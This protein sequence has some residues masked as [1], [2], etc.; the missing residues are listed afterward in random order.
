[1][2]ER[3]PST[4]Y[5]PPVIPHLAGL[6]KP[7]DQFLKIDQCDVLVVGTGLQES[8]LAAALSWQGTQVLHIDNKPYYGDSSSTMTIEQLKKWCADVNQGKIPHFQD[9]QIYIPGG[10]L[11]N[12]FNSRDY[13]IDLTPKIMFC[14]SDLLTLLVKSRVYRYLEFQSLSNFHVFENDDFQQK[15]MLQL[16]RIYLLISHYRSLQRDT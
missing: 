3:R 4:T 7:Q 10:K 9:A 13:G 6:E 15:S 8:I 1:M 14:Q 12:Q 11:S 5:T 16:S 2:A